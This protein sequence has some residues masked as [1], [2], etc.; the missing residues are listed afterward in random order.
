MQMDIR[1][2]PLYTNRFSIKG[3]TVYGV[4]GYDFQIMMF[5]IQEYC[6]IFTL[7]DD[8]D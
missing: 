5:Y 6:F 3:G 7:T 4:T 1:I 2:N 8:G